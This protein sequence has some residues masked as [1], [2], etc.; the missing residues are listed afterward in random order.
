MQ[1]NFLFALTVASLIRASVISLLL[2]AAAHWE[3]S[4]SSFSCCNYSDRLHE[5]GDF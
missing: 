4:W 2:A 5:V 3:N 1:C